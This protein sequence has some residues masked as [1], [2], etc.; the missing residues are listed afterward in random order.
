M[1]S[2]QRALTSFV[3]AV[4]KNYNLIVNE[5]RIYEIPEWVTGDAVEIKPYSKKTV[6]D[7]VAKDQNGYLYNIEMQVLNLMNTYY[8]RQP[9]IT[10]FRTDSTIIRLSMWPRAS[11][12]AKIMTEF[13]TV[14]I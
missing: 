1:L 5:N 4:L 10:I 3:R 11:K 2:N 6:F 7:I 12:R 9:T 13:L 14:S 8:D